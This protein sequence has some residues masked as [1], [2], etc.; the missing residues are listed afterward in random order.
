MEQVDQEKCSCIECARLLK[1]EVGIVAGTTENA[2]NHVQII[3]C[4]SRA[5]RG[6]HN[7]LLSVEVRVA[8]LNQQRLR[9]AADPVTMRLP[10]MESNATGKSRGKIALA[11]RAADDPQR[12]L[13]DHIHR[14]EIVNCAEEKLATKRRQLTLID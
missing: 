5:E 4:N 7:A 13:T 10:G 6:R 1:K 2:L 8:T 9:T 11:C 14:Q 12:R 3:A